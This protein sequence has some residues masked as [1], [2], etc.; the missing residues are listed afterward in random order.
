MGTKSKENTLNKFNK[1]ADSYDTTSLA[2][3]HARTLYDRVVEKLD[4]FAYDS[5]LDVGCGTGTVLSMI[6]HRNQGAKLHGLDLAPE[7]I[8]I[9]REKLGAN[10]ELKIGDSEQLPWADNSFDVMLCTDSFH[11]YPNPEKVLYEMERVLK[12]NGHL[13]IGDPWVPTPLRGVINLFFNFGN[14]G[15]VKMYS[16]EEF[17][18]ILSKVGFSDI[19]WQRNGFTIIVTAEVKK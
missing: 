7:M 2:V 11:H 3:K 9:A 17:V 16:G 10:A 18:L 15:D 6:R 12:S 8:K 5:I 13:I 4:L 14:S 1:M 19:Q